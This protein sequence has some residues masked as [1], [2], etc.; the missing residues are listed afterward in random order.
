M[1][2]KPADGSDDADLIVAGRSCGT[3]TLCCKLF[4]VRELD[5]AAGR[6]CPHVVQGRGCAIHPR[7]PTVCRQFFCQ[8]LLNPDLGPEWKPENAKFVLSIYPG[9]NSLAVTVDPTAA[10]AWTKEPY[11]RRL[12]QWA[13]AA[14]AR[15][16]QV[17]VFVGTRAIVILPDRDVALGELKP[18]DEIVVRKST[19]PVG[20]RYDAI[21]RPRLS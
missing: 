5:K 19:G 6:W 2:T 17:V 18:G 10:Q 7:R 21:V 20:Q 3:C 9:S 4:P 11:Y 15:H 1:I 16:Q 8:W 14:V 12:K 13:T